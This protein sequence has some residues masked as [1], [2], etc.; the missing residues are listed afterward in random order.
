MK[1]ITPCFWLIGA[2]ILGFTACSD[3]SPGHGPSD[4][5]PAPTDT[6]MADTTV[7]KPDTGTGD[8]VAGDTVTPDTTVDADTQNEPVV[9]TGLETVP[10]T[11]MLVQIAPGESQ[12]LNIKVYLAYSDDTTLDVTDNVLW[13]TGAPNVVAIGEGGKPMAAGQAQGQ[14]TL[15]ALYQGLYAN[16]TVTV[17]F[18]GDS[19]FIIL[20]EGVTQAEVTAFIKLEK[21][22]NAADA[23][24]WSYPQ[25]G[26]IIPNG[27]YPPRLQ[28]QDD[29][30][31]G[32]F[33]LLME[34][35]DGLKL[36]I[37]TKNRYYQPS[38]DIWTQVGAVSKGTVSLSLT[39]AA[40]SDVGKA[41]TADS[42]HVV[43]AVATLAGS[44]Y[45]WEVKTGSI[46]RLDSDK[47]VPAAVSVFSDN[48]TNGQCRGCHTLSKDGS[49]LAYSFNAKGGGDLGM[50]WTTAPEPEILTPGSGVL[51]ETMTFGP[52]GNKMVISDLQH[53]WL[54][55]VTPGIFG[56][57]FNL[58]DIVT[59]AE[60]GGTQ[61]AQTPA[62]SP[63]GSALAYTLSNAGVGL[64]QG[65][66][67]SELTLRFW[68]DENQTFIDPYVILPTGTLP[69]RPYHDYPTWTPDSKYLVARNSE[70]WATSSKN[71][72][73]SG[74][75]LVDVSTDQ[76]VELLTAAPVDEH[77]GRPHFSPFMEG[78]YY[79]LVFY[80]DRPYGN[81][82]TGNGKQLWV[83]AIDLDAS[84]DSDPSH[85]AFWL[86]GQDVTTVNLSGYWAQSYCKIAG[87]VC[88]E[89]ENCCIGL[90]CIIPPGE[91]EGSCKDS[92]CDLPGEYCDWKASNCCPNYICKQSLTGGFSCQP[93]WSK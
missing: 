8:S 10:S 11:G 18:T 32:F 13:T 6:A 81:V 50:A 45:Y 64:V 28:W 37:Y 42:H 65:G 46:M 9:V 61:R 76:W 72:G 56:G 19:P 27:M 74:L 5:Q 25:K 92:G 23:P 89:N 84:T 15:I 30:T 1:N 4:T 54:A 48:A 67:G 47:P 3:A 68:D 41:Y 55:D 52:S 20:D 16:L 38:R 69:D 83:T 29:L 51:A 85:P 58:G 17:K 21:S 90:E 35:E 7:V 59:V 62:W 87:D 82:K 53:M 44:V 14:S 33:Q 57:A 26:T 79:W 63:D 34:N 88:T 22:D 12:F 71:S 60:S 40:D 39:G 91:V 78:G 43:S 77:Y 24:N 70:K 66:V 2:L 73:L 86:P 49:K 75:T 36:T 31:P 80:T 93:D